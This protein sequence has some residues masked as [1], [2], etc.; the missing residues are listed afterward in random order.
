MGPQ[1]AARMAAYELYLLL[2][3]VGAIVWVGA[4][5]LMALLGT[6]AI[7]A[8]E[9]SRVTAFA[10]DSEWLGLRLFLPSNLVVLASG[11]LLVQE[12]KWSYGPLWI[13]LG[14]IGLGISL[15]I[16]AAFFGPGWSSVGKLIDRAEADPIA[17]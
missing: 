5:L 15:V 2:H 9:P 14:L 3:V 12:G 7:L 6:R 4:A 13:K 8:A 16:G 1:C 11:I 17:V 10:G